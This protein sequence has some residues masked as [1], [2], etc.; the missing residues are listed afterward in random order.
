MSADEPEA[1]LRAAGDSPQDRL[2]IAEVALA[3]AALDRPRVGLTR[4]RDHLDEL[5]EELRETAEMAPKGPEAAAAVLRSVLADRHGY[6]GDTATYDDP[7]NAN[8]MRVIDRKRGLPVA[9]GV[10][11]IHGARAAGW[12]MSGL[13]TPG[14][15][16]VRLEAAGGRVILDPFS[17][18]HLRTAADLRAL[19]QRHAGDRPPMQPGD[20]GA[21]DDRSVLLRLQNNIKLRAL[22]AG[23]VDKALRVIRS[24]AWIAPRMAPVQRELAVI[25]A[26]QGQMND[27]L[28]AGNRYQALAADE[29]Q[30]HDAAM[31]LQQLRARLN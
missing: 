6:G 2:D 8:L 10:L 15:F 12:E 16:L 11:Y 19:L 29:V 14:H 31:L 1:I 9:L 27:A 4:Y 5:S 24:M 28:V 18:G 26:H 20:I 22:Q 17:S 23:D 25:A 21:V 3:L 30:R 13:D 7:Q